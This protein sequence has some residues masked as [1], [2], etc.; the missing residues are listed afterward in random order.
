MNNLD[1]FNWIKQGCIFRDHHAQVPVA[2]VMDDRIRVYYSTRRDGKSMPMFFDVSI[3]DPTQVIAKCIHPILELGKPGSFDFA[4]VM[5]TA[6]VNFEEKKYLYYIGWST[7]HDVPYHNNLGL[8]ISRDQGATWEKF[9]EGPVFHTSHLEP[10]YIGTIDV[11][12]EN[13]FWKGWYLSCRNWI[14]YKGKMEPIYDI[15]YATSKD[16]INWLPTGQTAI[17]LEGQEG[18]ISAARV[19]KINNHYRMWFS[20]RNKTNYR[21]DS[22]NSYRI[23]TAR[24]LDGINW[25]REEQNELDVSKTGW[26]SEMVCYP[27]IVQLKKTLIMLYNGNGFGATGIGFASL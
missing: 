21:E 13:Q 15:K 6:L 5:P 7:R 18:G 22:S 17:K 4:G 9:S 25:Q 20:V 11:I 8:A 26:D 23:K 14:E 16:G 27:E 3:E 2:D 19:R 12:L 10:G 24:S 1:Y